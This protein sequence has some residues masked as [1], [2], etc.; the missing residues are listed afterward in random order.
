MMKRF[1]DLLIAITGLL[2]FLPFFLI[3]CII[4]IMEFKG[5]IFYTQ[6]RVGKDEKDFKL[7]KFR[8]MT[9]GSDKKGLLTIGNDDARTTRIGRILRRCK[10]DEMPQLFNVI[11]G[12]MSLVGPR[13][14]VRKYV[15]LYTCEQRKILT[16][17]P[18]ITDYASILYIDENEKLSHASD[19]EQFYIQ[20]I[21]P[22]KIN[23]NMKYIQNPSLQ[24]YFKILGLTIWSVFEKL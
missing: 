6:I 15:N 9:V 8:T 14:E 17:K 18:G 1:F 10:L 4:I 2:L 20:D 16:V 12:N 13:P 11:C 22:H 3:I 19:P 24:N 7:F 5:G 23:L 21:M